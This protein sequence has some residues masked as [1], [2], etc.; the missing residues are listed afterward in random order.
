[1][2]Y[3]PLD[4]VSQSLSRCIIVFAS[5]LLQLKQGELLKDLFKEPSYMRIQ[6]FYM[7]TVK[8]ASLRPADIGL[9]PFL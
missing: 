8:R 9:E 1:M 5:A 4:G 6:G 2:T 7:K 3:D